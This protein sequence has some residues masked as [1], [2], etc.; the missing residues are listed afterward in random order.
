[1]AAEGRAEKTSL[2]DHSPSGYRQRSRFYSISAEGRLLFA[3]NV[4]KYILFLAENVGISDVATCEKA[5]VE[6]E[7]YS[8]FETF[9][10]AI[11]SRV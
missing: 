4:A 2:G 9:H 7:S 5:R 6:L 11:A 3:K 8:T 1:L 10:A